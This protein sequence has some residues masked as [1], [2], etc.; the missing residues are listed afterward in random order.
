MHA[1]FIDGANLYAAMKHVPYIIDFKRLLTFAG[2]D[3]LRAAYYTA[4]LGD[5]EDYQTNRPLF[6][7]LEYNGYTLV[8]KQAKT[9]RDELTGITKVKGDM[10]VE[11]AVDMVVASISSKLKEIYLFSGDGDFVPAV[12]AV[13]R[14][15][16]KV[17][18]ISALPVTADEI[19]RAAD[20]FIDLSQ[21]RQL[22]VKL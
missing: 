15:C 16:V 5:S 20:C 13:Q 18:V 21:M 6:D 14:L 17:T 22:L 7:W 3:L 8:T 2:P 4:T 11:I 1:I 9:F 12:K 10:D 19:R